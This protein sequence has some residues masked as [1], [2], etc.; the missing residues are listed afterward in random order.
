MDTGEAGSGEGVG[1]GGR[2]FSTGTEAAAGAEAFS[3]EAGAAEAKETGA[4][5]HS[6]ME[7][8]EKRRAMQGRKNNRFTFSQADTAYQRPV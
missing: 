8:A 7:Q 3:E 6:S 1:T 2:V 4:L 5:P